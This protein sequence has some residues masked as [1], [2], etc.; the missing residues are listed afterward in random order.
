MQEV[1]DVVMICFGV[2]GFMLISTISK[3]G[4]VS[5]PPTITI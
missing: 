4:L 5:L 1:L 3:T 2:I